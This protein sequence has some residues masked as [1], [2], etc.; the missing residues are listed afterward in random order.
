MSTGAKGEVG[1]GWKTLRT[2]ERI[3][4][5]SRVRGSHTRQMPRT[6]STLSTHPTHSYMSTAA[7][8]GALISYPQAPSTWAGG[9][10]L[11]ANGLCRFQRQSQVIPEG[12][13]SLRLCFAWE[14]LQ[15]WKK[16]INFALDGGRWWWNAMHNVVSEKLGREIYHVWIY[17]LVFVILRTCWLQKDRGEWPLLDAQWKLTS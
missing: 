3:D 6:K 1:H 4:S 7:W 9:L 10:I 16:T 2:T 17:W 15:T 11:L 13:L 5:R 8:I 14:I 12:L